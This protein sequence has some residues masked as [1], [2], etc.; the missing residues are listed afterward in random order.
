MTA[1]LLRQN[2]NQLRDYISV[3]QLEV[4][5]GMPRH[6]LQKALCK[7]KIPIP[8][9]WHYPLELWFSKQPKKEFIQKGD[10]QIPE[11]VKK[12]IKKNKKVAEKYSSPSNKESAPA[13]GGKKITISELQDRKDKLEESLKEKHPF[14][15]ALSTPEQKPKPISNFMANRQKLKN[16]E[17]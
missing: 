12:G 14:Q 9:R 5:V 17:K 4:A 16:G 1:E 6:S 3:S 13:K 8:K 11:V 2:M 10:T 15:K 7:N